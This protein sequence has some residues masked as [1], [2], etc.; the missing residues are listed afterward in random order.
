MLGGDL[1][2]EHLVTDQ[3]EAQVFI[4][5]SEDFGNLIGVGEQYRLDVKSPGRLCGT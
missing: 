1:R 3:A 5:N 4:E 2:C